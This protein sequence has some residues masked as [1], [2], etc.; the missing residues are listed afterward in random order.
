MA[1][2]LYPRLLFPYWNAPPPMQQPHWL[3]WFPWGGGHCSKAKGGCR[4]QVF[5]WRLPYHYTLHTS[6]HP[7]PPLKIPYPK[8]GIW[9][10]A[11]NKLVVGGGGQ[12]IDCSARH[13]GGET[14]RVIGGQANNKYLSLGSWLRHKLATLIASHDGGS[15]QIRWLKINCSRRRRVPSSI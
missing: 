2:L 14:Q 11:N 7:P 5:M 10:Q 6:I 4:H 13:V 8:F 12:F 15:S 9:G 1:P 3:P